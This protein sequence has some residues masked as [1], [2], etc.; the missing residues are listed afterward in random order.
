M[1]S[2]ISI[3]YIWASRSVELGEIPNYGWKSLIFESIA[4]FIDKY[5]TKWNKF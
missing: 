4:I 5:N 2:E 1:K 3:I